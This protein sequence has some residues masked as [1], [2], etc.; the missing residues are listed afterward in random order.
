MG[1]VDGV[2]TRVECE[3]GSRGWP[4]CVGS[5]LAPLGC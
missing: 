3:R 1:S 2:L 4:A 5:M